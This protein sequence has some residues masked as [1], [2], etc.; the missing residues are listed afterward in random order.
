MSYL[1]PVGLN[2][3]YLYILNIHADLYLFHRYLSQFIY[4]SLYNISEFSTFLTK[5]DAICRF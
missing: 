4:E 3:T 5:A 1:N 2:L